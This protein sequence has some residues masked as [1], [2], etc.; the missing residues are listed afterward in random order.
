MEKKKKKNTFSLETCSGMMTIEVAGY[1]GGSNFETEIRFKLLFRMYHVTVKYKNVSVMI[2][3]I[4]MILKIGDFFLL[5]STA[6]IT[7]LLF[8]YVR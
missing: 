6:I 4:H 1:S 7:A 3:N 8:V 2:A 5:L